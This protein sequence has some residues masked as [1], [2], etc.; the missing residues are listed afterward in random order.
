MRCPFCKEEESHHLKGESCFHLARYDRASAALGN[1][2]RRLGVFTHCK[3][4]AVHVRKFPTLCLVS[5]WVL[6]YREPLDTVPQANRHQSKT[7]QDKRH[8]Q[9]AQWGGGTGIPVPAWDTEAFTEQIAF[10]EALERISVHQAK[11]RAG[12]GR[13]GGMQQHKTAMCIRTQNNRNCG[14]AR[15]C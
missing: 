10:A 8:A 11:K 13:A 15:I 1:R 3:L 5:G 9:R 12:R 14:V 4:H 6:T 2:K 7:Y